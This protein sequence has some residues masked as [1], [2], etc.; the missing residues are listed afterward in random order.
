MN[1]HRLFRM[2]RVG[3]DFVVGDLH[4]HIYLL[5]KAME[6]SDFDK[7]VDR[8]FSV[9]DLI[10]RGPDS[11]ACLR[12]V[13]EPWFHTV[14]GNHEEFLLQTILDDWSALDW[15]ENGGKWFQDED[16]SELLKLAKFIRNEVPYSITV[17]TGNGKVGICHAQPPSSDWADAINPSDDAIETMTSGRE[18]IKSRSQEIVRG[19]CK[20]IHGHTPMVKVTQYG[21]AVFIDTGAYYTG[22]LTVVPLSTICER[23]VVNTQKNS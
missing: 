21:N 11:M 23:T 18:W 14:I 2:N 1:T 22:R 20:T 17:V 5:E 10:D 12:L 6:H 4:G 7:D 15:L 16:E 8:M 19:V 13:K 9:G 3:R